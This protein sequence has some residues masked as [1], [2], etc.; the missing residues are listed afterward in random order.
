MCQRL[1]IRAL[2]A[3]CLT[4]T[5]SCSSDGGGGFGF[6]GPIIAGGDLSGPWL[7]GMDVESNELTVDVGQSIGVTVRF[8]RYFPRMSWTWNILAGRPGF[9]QGR[10]AW[11]RL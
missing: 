1:F 5:L 6:T 9:G 11:L 3:F 10:S 4:A 8:S 7:E 2:L